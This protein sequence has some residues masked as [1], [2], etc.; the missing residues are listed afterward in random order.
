MKRD[1]LKGWC[2]Q[3][4]KTAIFFYNYDDYIERENLKLD[5]DK[6]YFHSWIYFKF[7]N[8]EYVFDHNLNLLC[9]KNIYNKA[10]EISVVGQVMEKEVRDYLIDKI[11]NSK[12]KSEVI[13]DA[14]L[15]MSNFSSQYVTNR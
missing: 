9:K 11:D 13:K 1:A 14:N 12:S 10:F 6:T 5:K 4:T 15:F 7:N 3:T 2:W 8:E